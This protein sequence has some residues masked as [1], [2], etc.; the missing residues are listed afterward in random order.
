MFFGHSYL[1]AMKGRMFLQQNDALEG[2]G[3][4]TGVQ[5]FTL[6]FA[7]YKLNGSSSF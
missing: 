3:T 4:L 1:L 5:G 6:F 7:L 2:P